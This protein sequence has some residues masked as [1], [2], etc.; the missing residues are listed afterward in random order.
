MSAQ[1]QNY[2]IIEGGIVINIVLW[3]GVTPM[4]WPASATVQPIQSDATDYLIGQEAP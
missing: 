3:D 1:I 4:D 2:A